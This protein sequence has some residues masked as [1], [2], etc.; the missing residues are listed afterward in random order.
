MCFEVPMKREIM[1][2]VSRGWKLLDFKRNFGLMKR[3]RDLLQRTFSFSVPRHCRR[4]VFLRGF[5]ICGG[6]VHSTSRRA[7][8][9]RAQILKPRLNPAVH[10]GADFSRRLIVEQLV[11]VPTNVF[12]DR[13]Q[14]R[15]LEQISDTPV[16]QVVVV[17]VEFFTHFSR[18][19]VQQRFAELIFQT[20]AI[21]LAVKRATF[22]RCCLYPVELPLICL[23]QQQTQLRAV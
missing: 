21:S 18:D 20:L 12:Q 2:L 6:R 14:Q 8:L 15:T 3:G 22:A 10:H 11:E 4:N 1:A 5:V 19:R 23:R 9:C 17:L 13:I 7:A 16:P